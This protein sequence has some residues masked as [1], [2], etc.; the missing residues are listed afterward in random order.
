MC[1]IGRQFMSYFSTNS[2][3]KFGHDRVGDCDQAICWILVRVLSRYGITL[4]PIVVKDA[5][6]HGLEIMG[7]VQYGTTR[8]R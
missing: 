6:T 2:S 8:K 5:L 1:A 4:V 3:K 7:A